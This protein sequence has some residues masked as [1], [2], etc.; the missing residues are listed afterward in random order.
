[1][2]KIVSKT[3]AR[4]KKWAKYKEKKYRDSDRCFLVEG[5]HLLEEA[6]RA[7]LLDCILVEEGHTYDTGAYPCYEVSSMIMRKLSDSVSGTWLIG[8]CH[9]PCPMDFVMG[10]KVILL[11]DVQ[12]PGNVGTILRSAYS[13]GFDTVVLSKHCADVYSDKVIRS[14]Q[15]ALFHMQVI[16]TDLSQIIDQL[17]EKKIPVIG[18][19]LENASAM[20]TI[21]AVDRVALLFGNEGN[22]VSKEL[23]AKCDE[24][25]YIEMHAFESLNVAVA[26][27]IAMYKFRR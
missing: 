27:G 11:D 10:E 14:T 22:G 7:K 21:E 1:M 17:K 2:E 19:A 9:M 18:T 24:T 23:L 26:A 12:D 6:I 13:F 20:S 15:G 8:V 4:V 5:E 16:R 25:M 3:N